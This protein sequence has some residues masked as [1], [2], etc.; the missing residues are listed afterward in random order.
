MSVFIVEDDSSLV[1]L[2]S[3]MLK[4]FDFELAASAENGCYYNGSPYAH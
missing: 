1:H 3:K 2:Y 4:F